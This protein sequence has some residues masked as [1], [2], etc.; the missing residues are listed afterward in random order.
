[1]KS[2]KNVAIVLW[3]V[4]DISGGGGAE[5]FFSDFFVR[6]SLT[7]DSSFNLF[8]I[9]DSPTINQLRKANRLDN[10]NEGVILFKNFNNRLKYFLEGIQF[11]YLL[12]R[13]KIDLV[14]ISNYST[15]DFDRIQFVRKYCFFRKVKFVSTLVNCM[16]PHILSNKNHKDYLSY[17]L[18]FIT[19][20][21]LLRFE[22]IFTWY[23]SV[24]NF[25]QQSKLFLNQPIIQTVQSLY[26]NTDKFKAK[27][28]KENSFVYAARLEDNKKPDWYVH[29]I[30]LLL[31]IAPEIKN[32]WKFLFYGS[33]SLNAY[34]NQL[35][36]DLNLEDVLTLEEKNDLS[37]IFQKTSCFISAQDYEN[38]SSMSM[39]E[40]MACGNAVI[41]RNVGQTHLLVIDGYNGYYPDQDSPEGLAKA[42]LKYI[43]LSNT[44]RK[45]MQ[46]KS[47][48]IIL[49]Q[50]SYEKFNQI[51]EKFWQEVLLKS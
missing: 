4:H 44:E 22:G 2:K 33:G 5:R 16:I 49:T 7:A 17:Q 43:R 46:N 14:H 20:H 42:M 36:K 11:L 30:S 9:S 25:I 18:R 3:G 24:K 41:T 10:I 1:M 32:N 21:N 38:Y 34:I 40:A 8:L 31:S 50:H 37:D 51:I 23:D 12:Y 28:P 48:E 47:I 45:H 26:I 29:A 13:Y 15:Y 35:I 39:M 19:H 27:F 6:Y